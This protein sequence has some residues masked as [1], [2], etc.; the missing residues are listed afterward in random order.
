[1]RSALEVAWRVATSEATLLLRG[2]SGTG[3]GVLAQ[4]IHE[5]S[6][7]AGGPFVTVHCPSLSSRA[8]GERPVRPCPRR[9]YRSRA[10]H[11]GQG[12]RRR[13][14]HAVPRRGRRPAADPAAEAAALPA[15]EDLRARRRQPHAAAATSACWRPPTTTWKTPMPHGPVSRGPALSAQRH[16]DRTAALAAAAGRHPG[17]GP[18]LAASSSP[19]SRARTMSGFTAEALDSTAAPR[20]ARQPPR[21]AQR[22]RARRD[23]DARPPSRPGRPA[24]AAWPAPRHAGSRSAATSASMTWKPSTFAA[25]WPSVPRWTTPHARWASIPARSIANANDM[26]C[27]RAKAKKGERAASAHVRPDRGLYASRLAQVSLSETRI[28]HAIVASPSY[29]AALTPLLLLLA[30]QGGLSVWLITR[31]GQR[32]DAIL[33]ENYDSVKAMERLN[34]AAGAH[35][36]LIQ[37]RAMLGGEVERPQGLRRQLGPARRTIHHRKGQHHHPARRS[38]SSSRELREL[39]EQYREAGDRF[40]ALPAASKARR[41]IYLGTKGHP[42]L[43]GLF[44]EIKNVTGDILHI[45]QENMEAA[46]ADAKNVAKASR[47]GRGHLPGFGRR[48][49]AGD[50]AG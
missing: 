38:A 7:R 41:D 45:N 37:V 24:G 31:L 17:A 27:D 6:P 34:E 48:R 29:R 10:R 25:S 12:R 40:Y 13:G 32:I 35:R 20:L 11:R 49:G 14:R 47:A 28:S 39:K 21:A 5:R 9:L 2:E 19:A 18:A 44:Q 46:S 4:A 16:R 15:R 8:A 3:K 26:V 33:R 1:M 42:G 22:H 23:P 36:L 43:R 50:L 30:V